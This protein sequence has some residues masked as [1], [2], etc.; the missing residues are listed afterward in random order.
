MIETNLS[1]YNTQSESIIYS[2]SHLSRF[3]CACR[4]P[5]YAKTALNGAVL[6]MVINS[7]N[8]LNNV[9]IRGNDAHWMEASEAPMRLRRSPI[10]RQH[11]FL[12]NSI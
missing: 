1:I 5:R 10:G 4:T 9:E 7:I 6:A 2:N 11:Y 8:D 3:G 12:Y